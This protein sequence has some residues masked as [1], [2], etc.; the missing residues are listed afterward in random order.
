[1]CHIS[2]PYHCLRQ[3][4][5]RSAPVHRDQGGRGR[6][7]TEAV[8]A[9]GAAATVVDTADTVADVVKQAADRPS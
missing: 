3:R 7:P 9:V 4:H 5:P 1:M 2:H 6:D 8:T